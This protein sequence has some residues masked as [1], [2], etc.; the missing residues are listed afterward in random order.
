MIVGRNAHPAQ[1]LSL[2]RDVN[3]IEGIILSG[4]DG[5]GIAIEILLEE[6]D[7]SLYI[8]MANQHII[9]FNAGLILIWK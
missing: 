6:D 4:L 8:L 1:K 2:K 9:S 3:D 7:T 5:M